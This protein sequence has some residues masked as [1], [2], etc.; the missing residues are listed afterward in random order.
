MV[1][2][3]GTATRMAMKLVRKVPESKGKIPKCLLVNKGVHCVSKRKST[4]GTSLKKFIDSEKSTQM[5]PMVTKTVT[6]PHKARN[7]FTS[8]SLY[9][10]KIELEVSP[11]NYC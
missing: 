6:N 10:K 11:L 1:K 4:K 7:C 3:T 2:P 5:M 9:F 8:S